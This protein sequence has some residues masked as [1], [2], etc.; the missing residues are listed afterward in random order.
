MSTRA[1]IFIDGSWL[2]VTAN[3]LADQHDGHG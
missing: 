1:M 2:A 3:R